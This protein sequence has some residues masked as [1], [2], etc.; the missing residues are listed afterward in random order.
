MIPTRGNYV[1]RHVPVFHSAVLENRST[2]VCV[3]F[4]E[5]NLSV[6]YGGL[7]ATR[8]LIKG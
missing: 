5:T 3:D 6:T 2:I 8:T 4:V 7:K 1:I